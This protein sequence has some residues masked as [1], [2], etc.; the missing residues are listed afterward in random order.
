M[1]EQELEEN[2]YILDPTMMQ[3]KTLM[4][5]EDRLDGEVDIVDATSPF[6]MLV[7][8]NAK[9]ASSA[10]TGIYK[11]VRKTYPFLSSNKKELYSHITTSEL[12]DVFATPSKGSFNFYLNK[13]DMIKY[14]KKGTNYVDVIIPAYSTIVVGGVTFTMLN[15]VLIRL[16]DNNKVFSKYLQNNDLVDLD[17]ASDVVLESSVVTVAGGAE[18]VMLNL[19][20]T[21]LK[22]WSVRDTILR[23]VAYNKTIEFDNLDYYTYITASGIDKVGNRIKLD[24]THSNFMYDNLKPTL[25]VRP[26]GDEH[27]LEVELPV[28]YTLNELIS[29]YIELV[30]FVTRGMLEMP[31][32]KYDTNEFVFKKFNKTTTDERYLAIQKI[33]V[34]VNGE[35]YTVGGSSEISFE[36][37]KQKIIYHTTGDKSIPLTTY[38]M[39]NEIKEYGFTYNGVSN[40]VLEREFLVSKST[41]TGT[42]DVYVGL[43]TFNGAISIKQADINSSKIKFLDNAVVIEPWQMFKRDDITNILTDAE[44]DEMRELAVS[45]PDDYNQHN[46]FFNLYKYVLDYEDNTFIRAYDV[47]MPTLENSSTTFNNSGL[48]TVIVLESRLVFNRVDRYEL[49]YTLVSDQALF[50]LDL[51]NT[52]AQFKVSDGLNNIYY[53]GVIA[54]T[55][56]NL[57]ITIDI[58]VTN[59]IDKDDNVV[60]TD[61]LSNLLSLNV[62]ITSKCSFIIYSTD[63]SL[64]GGDLSSVVIDEASAILYEEVGEVVF[65]NRL[66]RL[67]TTYY[68]DYTDRKFLTY[69]NDVYEVYKEDV[70]ELDGNGNIV[71]TPDGNGGVTLNKLHSRGETVLDSEGEPVVVNSKG[72]IVLDEYD[73]P[74]IDDVF[75]TVHNLNILLLEDS[76]LRTTDEDYVSYRTDYFLNLT[77]TAD[78]L[79]EEMNVKLLENSLIKFIPQNSLDRVTVTQNYIKKS[80]PNF[81]SP[82]IE[83]YVDKEAGF[84][85][86]DK[87]EKQIYT[88]LQEMLLTNCKIID[89]EN[90]LQEILGLSVLSVTVK[91]ITPNDELAVLNYDDDSSRFVIKK[92]LVKDKLLQQIVKP[93]VRVRIITI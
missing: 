67:F 36:D 77:F 48:D 32:S 46:L 22:R 9:I 43:D 34:F 49:I 87:L 27:N 61:G 29:E 10:L 6:M 68:I 63:S 41:T 65:A 54:V 12:K 62:P 39:A 1:S 8:S 14:G 80:Y 92:N 71:T 40:T 37:L 15:D 30:I 17:V 44:S 86:T 93:D 28:V 31:L 55:N 19:L 50:D 42:H 7:E 66:E 20:V 88:Y 38:D 79:L 58:P 33:N 52:A 81:I 13:K 51:N 78:E 74:M 89:I 11:H 18:F 16:Y 23:S 70:Y 59:Y 53:K 25:T 60:L 2:K 64:V 72:S 5:I 21:Q 24:I 82:L 26:N 75:G 76:F 35:S 57:T 69:P 83:L 56:N 73:R 85:Y 90:G 3:V 84:S 47:N 4:E 45:N 91:D